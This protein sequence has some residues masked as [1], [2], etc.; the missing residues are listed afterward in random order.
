PPTINCSP[1]TT[2]RSCSWDPV[3]GANDYE[4]T[5]V[6]QPPAVTVTQQNDFGI[7]FGNLMQNDQVTISVAVRDTFS[8][9]PATV[10]TETCIAKDCPP[11]TMSIDPAPTNCLTPG[12]PLSIHLSAVIQNGTGTG[13]GVWP[14]DQVNSLGVFTPSQPGVYSVTYRYE[15]DSCPFSGSAT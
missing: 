15:E 3:A 2:A 10:V 7:T 14:G 8:P 6:S 1:S 4:I 11:I 9:C 5:I 13:I 12:T